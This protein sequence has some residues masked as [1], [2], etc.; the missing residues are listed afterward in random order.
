M[1]EAIIGALRVVLGADSAAFEKQMQGLSSKMDGIGNKIKSVGAGL[2]SFFSANLLKDFAVGAVTAFGDSQK[3]IASVET[4]LASMG[5]RVGFTSGKLQEMASELQKVTTFDDDEI[6]SKVTANLLTFGNVTGQAFER[7]QVAALDLSARL[8]QDLQSSAIQLGKALNDPIKGITALSKVGVSF[9]A[10]QQGMIKAMIKAGNVAGAQKLILDELFRQ[11]GGQAS[12]AAKTVTGAWEQAQNAIGDAMEGIGE[13]LAPTAMMLAEWVK[14]TAEAFSALDPETQK[15]VVVF[16]LLAAAIPPISLAAASM[17]FALGPISPLLMAITAAA[18]KAV[19]AL[20]ALAVANPIIAGLALVAGGVAYLALRQTESE[21]ATSAHKDA[22]QALDTAIAQ[23][24]AGVPGA[25]NQLKKIAE[26]HIA[27]AEAALASAEAQVE[28]IKTEITAFEEQ[29]K[30][31]SWLPEFMQP[32]NFAIDFDQQQLNV[33]LD[34]VDQLKR[35]L[36]E[37]KTKAG[38][39]GAALGGATSA[40]RGDLRG[41]NER[42][43]PNLRFPGQIDPEWEAKHI[44]RPP[45][46]PSTP[47]EVTIPGGDL[48]VGMPPAATSNPAAAAVTQQVSAAEQLKVKFDGIIAQMNAS[49]GEMWTAINAKFVDGQAQ[50]ISTL[51]EFA[52]GLAAEIEKLVSTALVGDGVIGKIDELK[53][54]FGELADEAEASFVKI[55]DKASEWLEGALGRTID[56]VMRKIDELSDKFKELYD[57]VVGHSYIPDMVDESTDWLK[58]MGSSMDKIGSDAVNGWNSQMSSMSA[59]NASLNVSEAASVRAANDNSGG[60]GGRGDIYLGGVTINAADY[61]SFK[62]SKGQVQAD[63]S[64]MVRAAF[65]GR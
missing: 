45:P 3:A 14:S 52:D 13:A 50:V 41:W 54:K 44:R 25:A 22:M 24:K 64:D 8:G 48:P 17:V 23:V 5:N 46:K 10:K 30:A 55:Y 51:S 31:L 32:G 39:A 58:K 61:A 29:R 63:L 19:A 36:D 49:V 7:A 34:L 28:A 42:F 16:G 37:L 65:A 33:Q 2:G 43:R 53:L 1:S 20:I 40:A 60:R 4:A 59:A 47:T 9:T 35:N 26:Q 27:N 57:K 6:L 62:Q 12:A 38:A 15:I 56:M 11:Y 21:K 18:W